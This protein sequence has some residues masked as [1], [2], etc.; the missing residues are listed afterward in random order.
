MAKKINKWESDDGHQYD[1]EIEAL[2]AD[3]D[4]WKR[5]YNQAKK[6]YEDAHV[7]DRVGYRG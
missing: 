6:L 7:D 1:T 4:Y 3:V 2:R 5:L